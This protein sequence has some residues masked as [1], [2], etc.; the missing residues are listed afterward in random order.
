MGHVLQSPVAQANT[1][2]P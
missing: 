2:A 1:N